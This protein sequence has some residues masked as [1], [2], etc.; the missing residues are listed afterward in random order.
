MKNTM[1]EM[2][3]MMLLLMVVAMVLQVIIGTLTFPLDQLL[4][5]VAMDEL[6]KLCR[7]TKALQIDYS[8]ALEC[9]KSDI[10]DWVKEIYYNYENDLANTNTFY[11]L[12]LDVQ[13]V[14]QRLG[15]SW[16]YKLES[17]VLLMTICTTSIILQAQIVVL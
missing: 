3:A 10:A 12:L 17:G 5:E 1:N 9:D 4:Q 15:Y 2:F 6:Y 8:G 13:T 7:E 14:L 11:A 16:T